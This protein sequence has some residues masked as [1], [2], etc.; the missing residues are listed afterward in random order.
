M[1]GS[2]ESKYYTPS[3]EEFHI[4]FE[5]ELLKK[6]SRYD[7]HWRFEILKKIFVPTK[8]N[9]DFDWIRLQIDLEDKEIRVKHLDKGD[10][11]SLG[12]KHGP[13]ETFYEKGEYQLYEYDL[14]YIHIYDGEANFVFRGT[15]K[16]K[17][18]LAKLMKQLNITNG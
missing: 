2:L 10:I 15:T 6:V 18:E 5:Y 12:W 14:G 8:A 13:R 17:S 1:S 16:N 11:E 3:I 7:N 9:R 4:G